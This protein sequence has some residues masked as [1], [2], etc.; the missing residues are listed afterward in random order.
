MA[1]VVVSSM[2]CIGN[3]PICVQSLD[4]RYVWSWSSLRMAPTP[5]ESVGVANCALNRS[6]I[7]LSFGPGT[8]SP[9]SP[10]L[11]VF[12][13]SRGFTVSVSEI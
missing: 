1:I 7:K 2:I 13:V 4:F 10:M 9:Q 11:M 3:L 5:T 12:C 6:S 8:V